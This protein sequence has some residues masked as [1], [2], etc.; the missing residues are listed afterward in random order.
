MI[1]KLTHF[2]DTS[3]KAMVWALGLFYVLFLCPVPGFAAT[4]TSPSGGSV[5]TQN[6]VD[7][8]KSAADPDLSGMG[9]LR[10]VFGDVVDNP[11]S[12]SGGETALGQVFMVINMSLLALG[13]LF[14]TYNIFAG[15]AQTAQDGEFLG[16]RFSSLW[17]PIRLTSGVLAL[18]PVFKGWCAAQLILLYFAQLGVGIG[19]MA[20]SAVAK[21]LDA[22]GTVTTVPATVVNQKFVNDLYHINLCMSSINA[23]SANKVMTKTVVGEVANYGIAGGNQCGAVQLPQ[24]KLIP[25]YNASFN[26]FQ[27]VDAVIA[28][29][30]GKL[31]SDIVNMFD[32]AQAGKTIQLSVGDADISAYSTIYQDTLRRNLA[33]NMQTDTHLQSDLSKTGFTGLGIFYSKLSSAS[34]AVN[35]AQQTQASILRPAPQ[36]NDNSMVHFGGAVGWVYQIANQY[37]VGF[38]LNKHDLASLKTPPSDESII[39]TEFNQKIA[40]AIP[41]GCNGAKPD[42]NAGQGILSKV[43]DATGCDPSALSRMKN[44]GDY[45]SVVGWIGIGVAATAKTLAAVPILGEALKTF[46]DIFLTLMETLTFFAS[47]LSTY[48]PLLPYIAW[49]GAIL[50]WLVVVIEGIVG[51]PLWAFAHLDTDGEGMGSRAE[52]GYLFILNVLFRPVLMVVGS[53]CSIICIDVVGKFFFM[54]YSGAVAEST[55]GSFTGLV[56]LVIYIGIFFTTS[57]MIVTTSVNLIHVVPDAV[58]N[59]IANSTASTAPGAGMSGNFAVGAVGATGAGQ[60]IMQRSLD[61]YKASPEGQRMKKASGEREERNE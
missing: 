24:S 4:T 33:A 18:V 37:M 25:A 51:A 50:S 29:H 52:H 28:G 49:L 47:M 8:A 31:A 19:N 40:Q 55:A 59:W 41:V 10:K 23:V 30:T 44:T 42:A 16:K 36:D 2:F 45:L 13:S 57:V 21:Y 9:I 34:D 32:D 15:V 17:V 43:I 46:A 20:T 56:A 27:T 48:L 58:L 14:L 5:T 7:A 11:L 12:P 61:K 26:A 54:T 6:M 3:T 38:N 35:E 22:G 39:I 60:S 1:D 53:L